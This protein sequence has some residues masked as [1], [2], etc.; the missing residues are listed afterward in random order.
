MIFCAA[1]IVT[2]YSVLS[3][4]ELKSALELHKIKFYKVNSEYKKDTQEEESGSTRFFNFSVDLQK[5]ILIPYM[6]HIKYSYFL[7]R[8]VVFNETFATI[9]KGSIFNNYCVM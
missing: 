3:N 6:P 4:S 8:L 7:I 5:V 9:K 2:Y 1:L